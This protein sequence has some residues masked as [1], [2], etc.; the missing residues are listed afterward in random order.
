[1]SWLEHLLP[2]GQR[3]QPLRAGVLN[4]GELVLVDDT[5]HAQIFSEGTTDLIRDVLESVPP[6]IDQVEISLQG[7]GDL[8]D[9]FDR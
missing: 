1:M 5:G 6:V 4:T 2:G 9:H 7:E 8:R 3:R